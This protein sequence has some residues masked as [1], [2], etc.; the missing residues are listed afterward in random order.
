[1]VY[2]YPLQSILAVTTKILSAS[3]DEDIAKRCIT[4]SE[5]QVD[6]VPLG[7]RKSVQNLMQE[8]WNLDCFLVSV[9][10]PYTKKQPNLRVS[11]LRKS[12]GRIGWRIPDNRGER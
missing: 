8:Q 5:S 9:L 3:F 4:K 11:C 7:Q 12:G 2:F 10:T 1:M 6:G